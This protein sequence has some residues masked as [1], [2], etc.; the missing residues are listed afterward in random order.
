MKRG[1]T[2][3]ELL[4]VIALI[5]VLSAALTASISEAQRSTRISRAQTEARE[6]TNA[7]L[8]YENEPGAQLSDHPLNDAEASKSTLSFILEKRTVKGI[9]KPPLF[10]AA[11]ANGEKILDPWNKPYRVTIKRGEK[12]SPPGVSDLKIRVFY[13]NWHRLRGGER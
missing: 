6:L 10:E 8:A 12:V 1:F 3:V 5:A 11:L 7:I 9:E 4:T 2:L 13:P